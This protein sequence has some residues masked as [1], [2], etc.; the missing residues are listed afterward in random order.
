MIKKHKWEAL[1]FQHVHIEIFHQLFQSSTKTQQQFY[2]RLLYHGLLLNKNQFMYNLSPTQQCPVCRLYREDESHFLHCTH[3]TFYKAL[4][5]IKKLSK[6]CALQNNIDPVILRIFQLKLKKIR[7]HCQHKEIYT[8]QNIIQDNIGNNSIFKGLIA[9]GWIELQ[10]NYL[11]DKG[12]PTNKNQAE[13]GV[14][15]LT[16]TFMVYARHRWD[17]RNKTAHKTNT[18]K[19]S[20]KHNKLIMELKN[21]QAQ[22]DDMLIDDRIL[23]ERQPSN[24]EE[25]KTSQI[26]KLIRIIAPIVRQSKKEAKKIGKRQ[27]RITTYFH[28]RKRRKRY[29]TPLKHQL[30]IPRLPYSRRPPPEPDPNK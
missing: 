17:I 18:D 14:K 11:Q 15:E 19:T 3:P 24:Y 23:L 5:R 30:P 1:T 29:Y 20:Y 26:A 4:H 16:R 27:R 22:K 2:T 25:L 7:Y 12:L 21:L 28:H 8:K 6:T 13:N 10:Q 9:K